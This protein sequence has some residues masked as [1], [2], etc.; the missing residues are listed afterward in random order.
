MSPWKMVGNRTLID[1]PY[2]D[3][4]SI[5]VPY[6]DRRTWMHGPSPPVYQDAISEMMWGT[7]YHNA[8]HFDLTLGITASVTQENS[9]AA[10]SFQVPLSVYLHRKYGTVAPAS[11]EQL[12]DLV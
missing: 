9:N 3:F 11:L 12:L 10:F 2:V 6:V 7:I 8:S 4:T 1:V 5:D